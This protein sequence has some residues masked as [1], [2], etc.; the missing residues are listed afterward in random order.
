MAWKLKLNHN[1]V[2]RTKPNTRSLKLRKLKNLIVLRVI[3]CLK[4]LIFNQISL[5]NVIKMLVSLRDDEQNDEETVIEP[6]KTDEGAI[7]LKN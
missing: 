5:R 6:D 2:I 7:S 4:E 3:Y 1:Q